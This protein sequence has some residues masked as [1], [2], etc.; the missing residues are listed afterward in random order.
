MTAR[1]I[2]LTVLLT[3]TGAVLLAAYLNANLNDLF[4]ASLFLSF[5]YL[6]AG[7]LTSVVGGFLARKGRRDTL[8]FGLTW[9]GLGCALLV[10]G[11]F[12]RLSRLM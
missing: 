8:Y 2:A 7:L 11:S 5:A 3:V 9:L 1:N 6:P 10:L 4:W 12:A